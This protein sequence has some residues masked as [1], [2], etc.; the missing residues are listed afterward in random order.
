MSVVAQVRAQVLCSSHVDKV[1]H[2]R[3]GGSVFNPDSDY[4]HMSNVEISE[5]L[6]LADDHEDTNTREEEVTPSLAKFKNPGH[7][8]KNNTAA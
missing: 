6:S 5:I 7:A 2:S 8:K 3:G 4:D 1:T